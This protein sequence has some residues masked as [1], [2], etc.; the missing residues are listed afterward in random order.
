MAFNEVTIKC[1]VCD[2]RY[3]VTQEELKKRTSETHGFFP[4]KKCGS[5]ATDWHFGETKK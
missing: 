1:K 2:S 5:F 4:C 3:K